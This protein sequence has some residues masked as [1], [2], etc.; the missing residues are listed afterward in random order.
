MVIILNDKI[1]IFL[2]IFNYLSYWQHFSV[3]QRP[4][5]SYDYY[6]TFGHAYVFIPKLR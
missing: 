4:K 1:W 5:N 2:W 6:W 3:P